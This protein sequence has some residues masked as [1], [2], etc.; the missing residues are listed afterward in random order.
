MFPRTN[1]V[2]G[3]KGCRNK[4]IEGNIPGICEYI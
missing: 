4:H 3:E 2:K 1:G